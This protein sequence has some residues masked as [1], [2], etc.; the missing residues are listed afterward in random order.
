MSR[1]FPAARFDFAQCRVLRHHWEATGEHEVDGSKLIVLT[2]TSCGTTRWDRWNTRTGQ[3]WGKASYQ[4]PDGYRDTEPGH[5]QDWW[6][7]TFADHL[8][9]QGVLSEAP[10][11]DTRRRAKPRSA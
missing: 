8:Y 6:R 9:R 4:W 11:A 7:A 5:D 2:C 3:R 10:R 1:S